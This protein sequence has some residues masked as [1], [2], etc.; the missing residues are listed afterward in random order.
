MPNYARSIASL[1]LAAAIGC[2]PLAPP[3]PDA[4]TTPDR[5]DGNVASDCGNDAGP[6]VADAGLPDAARPPVTTSAPDDDAYSYLVLPPSGAYGMHRFD[7]PA[8]QSWVDSGLYLHVGETATISATGT[9]TV[10]AGRTY[11]PGGDPSRLQ[12][13][14]AV[15]SLVARTGLVY[16]DTQLTCIGTGGTF[17]ATRD[18]IVFVGAIV[19]TDLGE[20]YQTRLDASGAVSVTVTSAGMTVPFVAAK[21]AAEFDFSTIESGWVEI[22]SDHTILTLPTSIAIRDRATIERAAARL[23]AIYASHR[24][25]RGEVPFRGERIRFIA[26]TDA[27]GWMLAGNPIRTDE[28]IIT[29]DDDTRITRAGEPGNSNWGFGHELG[30]EFTFVNGVWSYQVGGTLEGWPNVFTVHAEEQLGIGSRTRASICS[31]RDAYLA[32]GTQSELE[33]DPWLSLCFFLEF[34]DAYGWGF[35]ERFFARLNSTKSSEIPSGAK[36]WTFLRDRFDAAAG[37]STT[38]RFTAW[39]IALP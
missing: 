24:A 10:D 27:P 39:H 18:G 36:R 26:D 12:R 5:I 33:G 6:V 23:D 29:G 11:G 1:A 19:S 31:D 8:A 20:S 14:C 9:W 25:L 2:D 38:S 34:R 37:A 7:V 4:P 28:A 32:S 3:P 16:G 17:T 21:D 35:Y 30:H 22:Y 15:G 13:G